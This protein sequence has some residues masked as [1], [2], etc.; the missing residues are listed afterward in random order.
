VISS[1][2]MSV[3]VQIIRRYVAK[4]DNIRNRYNSD[5]RLLKLQVDIESYWR[6]VT[7]QVFGDDN[8][9]KI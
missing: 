9:V 1:S 8:N 7:F 6:C 4:G 3:Q 5:G 2:E